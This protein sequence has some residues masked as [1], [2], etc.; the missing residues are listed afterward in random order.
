[1]LSVDTLIILMINTASGGYLMWYRQKPSGEIEMICSESCLKSRYTVGT[2]DLPGV[3]FM[4]ISNTLVTD[5]GSYIAV[6]KKKKTRAFLGTSYV[7][8]A[9][10]DHT[11][12]I[13]LFYGSGIA[14]THVFQCEVAGAG[15]D[16]RGPY[17]EITEL[18]HVRKMRGVGSEGIDADGRFT[19]WSMVTLGSDKSFSVTCLSSHNHTTETLRTGTIN[20]SQG[21]SVCVFT[22]FLAPV[23]CALL[24]LTVVLTVLSARRTRQRGLERDG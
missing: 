24:V 16:L 4:T 18:G 12:R 6:S 3:G 20:I 10:T 17:W 22:Y 2:S 7:N 15:A 14:K 13:R 11:P 9:V 21:A 19:R 1:M 23:A 5:S 8:L